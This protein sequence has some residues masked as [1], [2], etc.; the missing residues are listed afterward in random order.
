MLHPT[1]G[2]DYVKKSVNEANSLQDTKE[3]NVP[4]I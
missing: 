3:I 1:N 4:G 2:I